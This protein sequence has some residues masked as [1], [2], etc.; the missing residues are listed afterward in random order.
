MGILNSGKIITARLPQGD[1]PWR[2]MPTV[3]MDYDTFHREFM[4]TRLGRTLSTI[5]FLLTNACQVEAMCTG[6][7]FPL[8]GSKKFSQTG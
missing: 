2:A 1:L 3:P 6:E 7:P 5:V 4:S 8:P